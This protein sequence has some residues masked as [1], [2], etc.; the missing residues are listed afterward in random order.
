MKTLILIAFLSL[1]AGCQPSSVEIPPA[2]TLENKGRFTLYHA[3]YSI[4][5]ADGSATI[6]GLFKIDSKTG[7][8]WQL[9]TGN[10]PA[11]WSEIGDH[12]DKSALLKNPTQ[13]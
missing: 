9:V 11:Y 2:K 3:E 10:G 5:R 8:T 1:I 6:K 13:Q 4:L 7:K 12:F